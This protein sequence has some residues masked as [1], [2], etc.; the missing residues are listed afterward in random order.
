MPPRRSRVGA[1]CPGRRASPRAFRVLHLPLVAPPGTALGLPQPHAQLRGLRLGPFFAPPRWH[2]AGQG[3]G[4]SVR[5][6]HRGSLQLR[7]RLPLGDARPGQMLLEETIHY[8]PRQHQTSL[9]CTIVKSCA[10]FRE[11]Y[12]Y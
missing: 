9:H 5:D 12:F 4:S 7:K 6:C 10:C 2:R 3:A 1:S 8:L 11:S